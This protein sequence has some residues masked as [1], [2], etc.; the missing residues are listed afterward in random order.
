MACHGLSVRSPEIECTCSGRSP[1][2]FGP[3]QAGLPLLLAGLRWAAQG[4]PQGDPQIEKPEA[5]DQA[6]HRAIRD[7]GVQPRRRREKWICIPRGRIP[8]RTA[9]QKTEVHAHD[10]AQKTL[11]LT[12]PEGQAFRAIGGVFC[13]RRNGRRHGVEWRV[14]RRNRLQAGFSLPVR[15]PNRGR[16]GRVE[17]LGQ[18]L[19]WHSKIG[20][21]AQHRN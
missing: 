14:V 11:R 15:L 1:S 13:W 9:D 18:V 17:G 12:Q 3:E 16:G 6:A 8:R 21:L 19:F 5:G 7:E 20:P 10:H 4:V 2:R